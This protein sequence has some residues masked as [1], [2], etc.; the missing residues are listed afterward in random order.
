MPST[1]IL[2][3]DDEKP[4][5]RGLA[6]RLGAEPDLTVVGEASDGLAGVDLADAMKPDLVL[7]D[8]RMPGLDGLSAA[9]RILAND[10]GVR[11]IFLTMHDDA[12][13]R[14]EAARLGAAGV[15]GKQMIDEELIAT[16]RTV[17][18]HLREADD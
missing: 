3:V 11:V 14:A 1:R 9:A 4:I 16:I 5:R 13:V 18:S 12:R 10:P 17:A 8:V 2:I 6:M 15:V 7:M